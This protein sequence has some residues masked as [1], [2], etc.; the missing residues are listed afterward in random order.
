MSINK[1]TIVAIFLLLFC[2]IMIN[3]SF[4]IEDPGYQGMKASFWPTIVLCLLSV[5][6]LVMLI[7]SMVSPTD[8]N[9]NS[10]NTNSQNIFFKYKNASICFL[11]FILFLAFL[12][13]LG[14]LIGGVLFVFGLLTLLGGFEIKK[15]YKSFNYF[16]HYNRNYVVNIYL[17]F[18]SYFT[19]RRNSKNLVNL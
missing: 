3:S 14:M 13:Y 8:N 12:D 6:S 2:G 4:D 1:D 7:K 16:N 17:W 15:N 5:M 18:K 10:E 9:L 11:M 19:R